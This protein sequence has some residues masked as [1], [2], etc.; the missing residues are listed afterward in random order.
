[1]AQVI[2][3]KRSSATGA[4]PTTGNLVLGELAM[5]TYEGKIFFEKNDGTASIQ[6]I[7]TTDSKTTGSIELT[8]DVTASKFSGDGSALTNVSDPNAVV[9]GIVFASQEIIDG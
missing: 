3:L 6:T 9:F 7:L 1:M 8:G 2:K 5:N 4:V